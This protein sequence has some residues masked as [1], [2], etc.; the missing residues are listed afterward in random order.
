M[1]DVI[2]IGAGPAG[3]S[4]AIYLRRANKSVL[5]LEE[6]NKKGEFLISGFAMKTSTKLVNQKPTRFIKLIKNPNPNDDSISY[7]KVDL[8]K[9]KKSKFFSNPLNGWHLSQKDEEK[10]DELMIKIKARKKSPLGLD[11]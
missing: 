11:S 5:V 7:I 10:I 3:L 8:V 6:K 2:V 1:Y 9:L 4:A